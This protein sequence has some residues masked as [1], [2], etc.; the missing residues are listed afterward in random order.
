M[1][2]EALAPSLNR[3]KKVLITGHTGFKG[4]WLTILL[5]KLGFELQGISLLPADASLYN[6]LNRL[7]KIQES[8]IDITNYDQLNSEIS[9]FKPS[10]VFHLAAQPLVLESYKNPRGTF[11]TNVMGTV[12]LLD[13]LY[14]QDSVEGIVV[15]TTDKVYRNN[16]SGKRFIEDDPLSGKDPYSASKVGT[17]AAINAWQQISKVTQAPHVCAVRAGNVIGG[18]DF[19]ADRLM[20][21]LVRS[22]T[23]GKALDVR[24]PNSTRPWQHVLDPLMGYLLTM[25]SIVNGARPYSYNFGPMD[26]SLSVREVLNIAETVWS[27]IN[28]LES[29]T[30]NSNFEANNLDLDSD[31]AVLELKWK[32]AWSQEE[33]VVATMNWWRKYLDDSSAVREITDADV[34][35]RLSKI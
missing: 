14:R 34:E 24:S 18:G 25:D 21:D 27:N 1:S 19:A 26:S 23:S 10:Y 32:P 28:L 30:N 11:S 31:K 22:V 7:G 4:T 16:D 6:S 20:P 15:S 5:E 35:Y 9:R 13:S 12:N 33:A 2:F 3:G 17:E 8:F 29:K